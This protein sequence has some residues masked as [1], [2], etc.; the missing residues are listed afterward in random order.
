MAIED[1]NGRVL[2]TN[3]YNQDGRIFSQ[4]LPDGSEYRYQYMLDQQGQVAQT[5]VTKPDHSELTFT[6][7]NGVL[8]ARN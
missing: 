7:R 6:R 3:T 2:I 4:T 1:E 8:I 5:I